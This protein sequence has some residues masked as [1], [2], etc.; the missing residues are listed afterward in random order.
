MDGQANECE[1]QLH[2][3]YIENIEFKRTDAYTEDNDDLSF[4]V[5]YAITQGDDNKIHKVSIALDVIDDQSN[6]LSIK[7]IVAGI[8]SLLSESTVGENLLQKNTLAILFPY[9][10]SFLTTVTSQSGVKP[11]ILPTINFNALVDNQELGETELE[12]NND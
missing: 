3:V 7:I 10:R 9:V 5:G 12:E 2:N 8:F 6:N 1:L 11:L 4:K